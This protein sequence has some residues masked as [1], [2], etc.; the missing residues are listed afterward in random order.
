MG[1]I[2][3]DKVVARWFTADSRAS[4]PWKVVHEMVGSASMPGLA[5]SMHALYEYD[6]SEKMREIRVPGLFV[7][8]ATDCIFPEV[9]SEFPDRMATGLG[10]FVEIERAGRLPML[11]SAE[12]FVGV[13][14]DFLERKVRAQEVEAM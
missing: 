6:E 7:A 14:D 3:A 12:A 4:A 2:L 8:G 9:M 10:E 11:E 1:G 5:T 13:L